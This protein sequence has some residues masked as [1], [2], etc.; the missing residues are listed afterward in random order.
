[1]ISWKTGSRAALGGSLALSLILTG[2]TSTTNAKTDETS[3]PSSLKPYNIVWY[4]Y[5]KPQKD[6]A[7]VAQ[8]VSD[9][10]KDKINATLTIN[11]IATGDYKTKMP[12]IIASQEKFDMCFTANWANN[13]FDNATKGAFVDLTSTGLLDKYG[14]DI[15]KTVDSTLL[16][17]SS[18]NGKLYAVPVNKEAAYQWGYFLNK[19]YIDK[20]HFDTST[21]KTAADLEPMLKTI[22]DNE[23]GVTP[24]IWGGGNGGMQLLPYDPI[25]SQAFPVSMK[26]GDSSKKMVNVYN[27]DEI[28]NLFALT[29]KFYQAGY[30]PKDILTMDT[31]PTLNAGKFFADLVAYTPDLEY[32]FYKQSVVYIP[33]EKPIVAGT[34]GTGAMQAISATSGDKD[35]TMMFLNLLY[36]DAKLLNMI[37]YG[38]E[39]THYTKKSDNVAALPDGV[40]T[41]NA[42]YASNIWTVG[43]EFLAYLTPTDTADKWSKFKS[44]NKDA[45]QSPALGFNFDSSNV[46]S[47]VAQINTVVNQY[48]PSLM[49]GA[50]DPNKYLPEFNSK[51]NAAGLDNVI[52][53]AQTQFD[54][55]AKTKK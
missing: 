52:K 30:I 45:L 7:K 35:R 33:L 23:P 46:S 13:Y 4:T 48:Y 49:C 17:G 44:F 47:E 40:T 22:K 12:V 8:A 36:S 1:M 38:I 15:K 50:V 27:T 6:T 37:D 10:L 39:G 20:Y 16:T 2:C 3:N 26:I 41:A 5:N 18:I 32:N 19:T 9:Y 42:A 55:W 34:A 29:H 31:A 53:E 24:L 11:E 54:K 43:N 51:L 21:V 14:K 25:I 28:K